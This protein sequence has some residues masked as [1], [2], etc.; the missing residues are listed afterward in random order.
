MNISRKI[1]NII[2]HEGGDVEFVCEVKSTEKTINVSYC[3]HPEYINDLTDDELDEELDKVFNKYVEETYLKQI[4]SVPVEKLDVSEER[5][6]R[7]KG[8]KIKVKKV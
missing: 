6:D 2:K 8:K 4:D 7:F 3:V 5:L 1:I